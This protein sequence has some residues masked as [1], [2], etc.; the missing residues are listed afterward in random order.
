M[1]IS[2]VNESYRVTTQDSD[3]DYDHSSH[4]PSNSYSSVLISMPCDQC[5]RNELPKKSHFHN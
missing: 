1:K 3:V 2:S 4:S 5:L